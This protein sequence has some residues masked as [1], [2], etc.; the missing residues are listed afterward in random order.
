[1]LKHSTLATYLKFGKMGIVSLLWQ[2]ILCEHDPT[3]LNRLNLLRQ[4]TG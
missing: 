2:F 1:M 3:S 4:D